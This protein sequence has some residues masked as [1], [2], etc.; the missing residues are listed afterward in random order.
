ML[1]PP[2][3]LLRGDQPPEVP[4]RAGIADGPSLD[5]QPLRRDLRLRRIDPLRH[6]GPGHVG[7]IG[8]LRPGRT[9]LVELAGLMG[10]HLALHGL[11]VH[12]ADLGGTRYVPTS[13]NAATTSIVFLAVN[14]DG[15]P[16]GGSNAT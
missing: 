1:S 16:P 4:G 9:R 12:T 5:Q 10:Q 2:L 14:I 3:L 15:S 6:Q 13:R 11:G 8:H 7:A